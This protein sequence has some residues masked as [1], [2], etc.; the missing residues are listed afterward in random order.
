ML[1][2]AQL[3]I[4]ARFRDNGFS[5]PGAAALATALTPSPALTSRPPSAATVAAHARAQLTTSDLALLAQLL[6]STAVKALLQAA[7]EESRD[8]RETARTY[9]Q[10]TDQKVNQLYQILLA[11][12]KTMNQERSSPI[13]NAL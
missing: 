13:K 3:R 2:S 10:G 7:V 4:A 12:M 1:S 8:A 9:F 11:I 6:N 5:A